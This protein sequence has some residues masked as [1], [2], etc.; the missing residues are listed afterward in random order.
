MNNKDFENLKKLNL[1][2]AIIDKLK[3]QK[4]AKK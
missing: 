1:I 2:R 4:K 3:K